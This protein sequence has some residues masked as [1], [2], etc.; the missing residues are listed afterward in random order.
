V[1]FWGI[2]IG[3]KCEDKW[4]KEKGQL[5]FGADKTAMMCT[6]FIVKIC[7]ANASPF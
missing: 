1:N 7:E 3:L 5:S 6:D 2:I 4:K